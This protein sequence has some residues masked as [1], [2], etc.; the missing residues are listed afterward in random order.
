MIASTIRG[1]VQVDGCETAVS[2]TSVALEH[3]VGKPGSE[4]DLR[5]TPRLS[6]WHLLTCHDSTGALAARA[7][8]RVRP[9]DAVSCQ[10]VPGTDL[11]ELA[12]ISGQ[13]VSFALEPSDAYGNGL[14]ASRLV[15]QARREHL[16]TRHPLA[17]G[18]L[19]P[20]SKQPA[21]AP[22]ATPP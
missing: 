6:G 22:T 3:A 13:W 20:H 15:R 4:F 2:I 14:Q 12:L 7:R 21:F 5:F 10:L 9:A 19:C 1:A 8:L 16:P 11:S 17:H 18:T